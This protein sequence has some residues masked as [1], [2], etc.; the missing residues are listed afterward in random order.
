[1][2]DTPSVPSNPVVTASPDTP[3]PVW[4]PPDDEANAVTTEPIAPPE[5][6]AG[7]A[8]LINP[9]KAASAAQ[10]SAPELQGSKL[11]DMAPALDAGPWAAFRAMLGDDAI[12]AGAAAP[13]APDDL[14][15]MGEQI[16]VDREAARIAAEEEARNF[17]PDIG[18]IDER[19][20]QWVAP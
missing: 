5:L 18:R 10:E 20:K 6:P 8:L 4:T 14:V 2:S 1:M 13:G 12:L 11:P 19:S 17:V 16:K 3:A 15:A 9:Q 7:L